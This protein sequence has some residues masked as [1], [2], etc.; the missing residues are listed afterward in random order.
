MALAEAL[1]GDPRILALKEIE[2]RMMKEESFLALVGEKDRLSRTYEEK[3][4]HYGEGS[5]EAKSAL[6]E[7]YLSKKELD[8]HPLTLSYNKAYKEVRELYDALDLILFAPYRMKRVC[9]RKH[10]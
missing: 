4:R 8:E 7:L 5:P 3:C 10:G 1:Q 6:H 9:R 2:S